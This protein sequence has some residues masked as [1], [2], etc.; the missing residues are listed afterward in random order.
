[1]FG[2]FFLYHPK[3]QCC[4]WSGHEPAW[5][6][7]L[8][9]QLYNETNDM[10]YSWHPESKLIVDETVC[11]CR[12][13]CCKTLSLTDC[14]SDTSVVWHPHQ[15]LHEMTHIPPPSFA[16]PCSYYS[17]ARSHTEPPFSAGKWWDRNRGPSFGTPRTHRSH[18]A[19]CP[20]RARC[21]NVAS[22][23]AGYDN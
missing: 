10:P 3:L 5:R 17:R 11:E 20:R 14:Y 16:L 9:K 2:G 23:P 7:T 12:I 4:R 13:F 22:T 18:I 21:R 1:M 8:E 19:R 6:R 15:Q